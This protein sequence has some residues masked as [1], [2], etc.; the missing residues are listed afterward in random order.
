VAA[1]IRR[2]TARDAPG[3]AT[4]QVR[5][6]Q[7]AYRGRLPQE[8]LDALTPQRREPHWEH[9]V[10]LMDWPRTGTLVAVDGPD[11][12]GFVQFSPGRDADAETGP[13]GEVN[14]IY[15]L[16]S[17]WGTGAGR[18]LMRGAV[19]ALAEAGFR[20]ATLWVLDSNERARRFYAAAGWAPDGTVQEDTVAGALVTEVRYAREL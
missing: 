8:Y 18:E 12:V 5:S 14:A 13:S 9:L 19:A 7:S 15:V 17:A 20:R 2:A 16:P 4:V 1:L 3:I 10:G 6:W 11:L